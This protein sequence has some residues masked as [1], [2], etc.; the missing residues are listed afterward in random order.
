M[1]SV[2]LNGHGRICL[3]LNLSRTQFL[4]VFLNLPGQKNYSCP[5]LEKIQLSSRGML[6]VFYDFFET[7][8]PNYSGT[9]GFC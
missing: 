1:W 8:L 6:H 9:V 2:K 5:N 4:V 3:T 7:T